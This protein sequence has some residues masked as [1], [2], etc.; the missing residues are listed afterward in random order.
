[1][2]FESEERRKVVFVKKIGFSSV[3]EAMESSKKSVKVRKDPWARFEAWRYHPAIN[4]QTNIRNL[5][6][7]FWWGIGAFLVAV[8]IEK[9]FEKPD[10]HEGHH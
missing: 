8:A 7:G 3:V 4:K 10:D 5:I 9:A 2:L 6:P 1:M